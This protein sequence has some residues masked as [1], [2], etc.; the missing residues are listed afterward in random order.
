MVYAKGAIIAVQTSSVVPH[1][2]SLGK[3]NCIINSGVTEFVWS[4]EPLCVTISHTI[5]RGPERVS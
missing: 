5:R 3:K 2:A 4:S 1:L